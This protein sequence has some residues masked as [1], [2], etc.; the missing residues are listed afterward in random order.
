MG[1]R[2]VSSDPRSKRSRQQILDA[3]H[4]Q[5]RAGELTSISSLSAAAGVTRA[6]FYNHFD[7]IEEAAWFAIHD[8]FDHILER[9][10]EDRRRG[11][12]FEA[13][14][15]E[16]LRLIVEVFRSAPQLVRLADAY[17]NGADL[18][19]IAEIFRAQ[20]AIVWVDSGRESATAEVEITYA[21]AG[22]Y[23][24]LAIGARGEDDPQDIARVAHAQLP[25]WMRQPD[26]G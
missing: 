18:T 22:L 10:F 2:P 1:A 15:V 25:E 17:D 19:G 23:A 4:R 7:T 16:S 20:T 14:G 8:N 3:V 21:A 13:A 9:A 26:R 5:A 12:S 24:V 6:T 11:I